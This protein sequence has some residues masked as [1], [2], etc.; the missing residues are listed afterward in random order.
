MPN[1]LD[2]TAFIKTEG[3]YYEEFKAVLSLLMRCYNEIRTNEIPKSYEKGFELEN[4]LRNVLVKKYLRIYKEKFG[5]SYLGFE[6]ESGEIDLNHITVGFI[7]IKVTNAGLINSM[8]CDEDIYY[9]IECKRLNKYSQKITGYVEEGIYRFV[10]GKYSS[11]MPLAC[12]IGFIEKNDPNI[13]VNKINIKLKDD[14]SIVTIQEL[15]K[16][17]IQD[18]FENS[19]L[20]KHERK[21]LEDIIDIYHLM[22]DYTSL[23]LFE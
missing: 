11:K 10:D 17:H 8:E 19:Y 23:I 16:Y 9:A 15:N 22:F 14:T 4:H 18:D 20:S 5:I 13:I 1:D 2:A 21:N 3:F 6:I 7:D 12:M